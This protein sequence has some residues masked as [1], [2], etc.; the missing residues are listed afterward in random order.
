[1]ATEQDLGDLDQELDEQQ[2]TAQETM[3][4]VTQTLVLSAA[5]VSAEV[6]VEVSDEDSRGVVEVSG[7]KECIPIQHHTTLKHIQ[8]PAKRKKKPTSKTWSKVWK[9]N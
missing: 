5:L 9:K 8:N 2:D 3:Y 7:D 1:V 4:L 6:G